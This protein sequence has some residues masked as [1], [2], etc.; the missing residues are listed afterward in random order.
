MH[1][2]PEHLIE[3]KDEFLT[4]C[5]LFSF[6]QEVCCGV[7]PIPFFFLKDVALLEN[8]CPFVSNKMNLFDKFKKNIYAWITFESATNVI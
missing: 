6:T 7:K 8:N 4:S 1:F 3:R 2:E 5:F